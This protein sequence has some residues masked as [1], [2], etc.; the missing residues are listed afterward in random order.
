MKGGLHVSL[1]Y[2]KNKISGHG[3]NVFIILVHLAL[4]A[5]FIVCSKEGYQ[6]A[7]QQWGQTTAAL[8]ISMG[9]PILGVPI[10]FTIMFL[11][12]VESFIKDLRA[13]SAIGFKSNPS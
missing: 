4:M 7:A 8:R 3:Q 10:G 6:Y 12:Q 2:V 13:M 9:I 1:N 11:L 5:F